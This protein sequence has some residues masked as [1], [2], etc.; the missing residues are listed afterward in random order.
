MDQTFRDTDPM[1]GYFI[2]FLI[3]KRYDAWYGYFFGWRM[4]QF[5][6]EKLIPMN[7]IGRVGMIDQLMRQ[8]PSLLTLLYF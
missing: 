1:Q 3:D 8:K 2:G 6:R 4:I 5:L 7:M